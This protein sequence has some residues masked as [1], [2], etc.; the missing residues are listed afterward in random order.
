MM[1]P[2]LAFVGN[3]STCDL[4]H[5]RRRRDEIGAFTRDVA[6]ELG[7]DHEVLQTVWFCKDDSECR[8]KAQTFVGGREVA[9]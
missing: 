5:R 7:T 6:P 4:C 1:H 2:T 8:G 9:A 3:D